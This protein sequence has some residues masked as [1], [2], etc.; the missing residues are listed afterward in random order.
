MYDVRG[1]SPC[2]LYTLENQSDVDSRMPLRCAGYDGAAY[3]RQ[4]KAGSGQGIYPVISVVLNW[5]EKP[6]KA[7]RSIRELLEHPIHQMAEEYLDKNRIHVFDMRFLGRTVRERFE[8]DIRVVLDYLSDNE[9][10]VRRRQKLRNP[11][12][13]MRM[14]YALSGDERYLDGI[15]MM[16]EEGERSVCELL[17]SMVN[18]GIQQGLQ[19]GRQ[20][21]VKVLIATYKEFGATYE[22]TAAGVKEKYDLE[23]AEVQKDMKMYW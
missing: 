19:Q 8:G 4:Y 22:A 3:R 9:S 18:K 11:E 6:W 2:A 5:G 14:L 1:G 16:E 21:G 17:D 23:D 13:V 12:E 7:A 10:L 15:K 20:Q